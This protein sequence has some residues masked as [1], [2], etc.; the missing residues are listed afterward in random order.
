MEEVKVGK[1]INIMGIHLRKRIFDYSME[2]RCFQ[3]LAREPSC[4]E[5][6]R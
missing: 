2:I 6:F 4:R 3:F 5:P 1:R